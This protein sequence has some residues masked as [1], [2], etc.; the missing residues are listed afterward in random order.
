MGVYFSCVLSSFS[1]GDRRFAKVAKLVL[2]LP[3][4]NADAKWVFSVVGLNKT[5][6][7]NGF[8][9]GGPLSSIMTIKMAGLKPCFKWEPWQ[10][11]IEALKKGHMALQPGTHMLITYDLS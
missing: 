9:L 8:A 5:K 6:K 4:T 2:V 1:T 11:I 10:V 3:H 7:R